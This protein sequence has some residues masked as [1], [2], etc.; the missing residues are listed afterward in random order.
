MVRKN[1]TVVMLML[2][3]FS[4]SANAR[5]WRINNTAGVDADFNTVQAALSSASVVNDD[6]LYIEGSSTNYAGFTLNKRL[7]I[8]STGYFL[9]GANSNTGLQAGNSA[10][11]GGGYI[12]FDSTG[13]GTKLIG[14]D[15]FFMG[16][17]SNLGSATD[18]ISITRC[19]FT[20]LNTYYSPTANTKMVGWKINKCYITGTIGNSNLV[21]QDWDLRNNIFTSGLDMS[22]SNNVNNLIRNNVFRSTVDLYNGYFANNIIQ[23][24][25]FTVVNV[26]IKNN[27]AI[28]APAGFTPYVGTFGNL[29]NQTDATLFQGLTGNSTDGQWRLKA[30]SPAIGAG[31]T[32]GGITP[33]CGAFNAQDGYIL[34][35]IPNI[36]SIYELTVPASIPAG[37]ATMN[38]TL[39]TRNN[40]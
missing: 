22:N 11:F 37:T 1:L 30:G 24:T 35:G 21:M 7:V 38:V 31:L 33:D 5:V 16:I 2:F 26:T 17:G 29:N 10:N 34:S 28:G 20:G 32:V 36:P 39:S 12:V 25:T 6:T 15:N 9:T 14:L 19:H 40:N 4:F 8:I 18:N 27:L 13:S 23:N 3:A